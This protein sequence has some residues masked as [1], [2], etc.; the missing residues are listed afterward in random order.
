MV[1]GRLNSGGRVAYR[2]VG[3]FWK[4]WRGEEGRKGEG[5]GGEERRI[6]DHATRLGRADPTRAER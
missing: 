5:R 4:Q 6:K 2:L 1:S 3:D